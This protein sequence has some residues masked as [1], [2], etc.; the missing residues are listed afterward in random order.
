M[1][2]RDELLRFSIPVTEVVAAAYEMADTQQHPLVAERKEIGTRGVL[3]FGD[4]WQVLLHE[5]T[6]VGPVRQ[7]GGFAQLQVVSG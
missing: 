5:R 7:I 4:V 1:S 6:D 3:A 2:L